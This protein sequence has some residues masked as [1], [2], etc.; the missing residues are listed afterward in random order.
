[1][2]VVITAVGPDNRGLA[3]PIIHHVTGIGAS[4][5]ARYLFVLAIVAVLALAA[6][7]MVRGRI[8]RMWMAIRDMDIAAEIIGIRPLRTKLIAVAVSSF[9]V[10]IGGALWGF[11]HLAQVEPSAFDIDRSRIFCRAVRSSSRSSSALM[12]ASVSRSV[13]PF[14]ARR[15]ASKIAKSDSGSFTPSSMRPQKSSARR[16]VWSKSSMPRSNPVRGIQAFRAGIPFGQQACSVRI[17]QQ[18]SGFHSSRTPGNSRSSASW[19]YRGA[20]ISC[21]SCS[22]R[23]CREPRGWPAHR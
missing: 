6:K 15:N 22:R 12:P 3:D 21:R 8:G 20:F 17:H 18:T 10:G 23:R 2:Q 5:I 1:M 14:F 4:Y 11:V 9:Y 19:M 13:V 7:N 16:C